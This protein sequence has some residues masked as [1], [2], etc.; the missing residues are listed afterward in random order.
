MHNERV[1]AMTEQASEYA[2]ATPNHSCLDAAWREKI[3]GK[4]REMKPV[5]RAEFSC[6]VCKRELWWTGTVVSQ[7]SH[8]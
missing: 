8:F 7:T 4:L 6:G 5:R 2:G 3:E 1:Y